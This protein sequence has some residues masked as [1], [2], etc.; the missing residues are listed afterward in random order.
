MD[1]RDNSRYIGEI[2]PL[3]KSLSHIPNVINIPWHNN[4]YDNGFIKDL[5]IIDKNFSI[6]KI[7]KLSLIADPA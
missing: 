2:E 3:Y 4:I 1:C 5:N 6:L 7:K